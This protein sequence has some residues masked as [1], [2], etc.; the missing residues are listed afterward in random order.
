MNIEEHYRP[1]ASTV[2]EGQLLMRPMSV[3]VAVVLMIISLAIAPVN[4]WLKGGRLNNVSSIITVVAIGLS[5]AIVSYLMN[6]IWLRRNWARIVYAALGIPGFFLS[7]PNIYN[8][9]FE[10]PLLFGVSVLQQSFDL[11]ALVLLFVKRS[12]VWFRGEVGNLE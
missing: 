4:F 10:A 7:L 3:R 8:L 5:F 1:P 12:N 6:R 9:F 11:A 2:A